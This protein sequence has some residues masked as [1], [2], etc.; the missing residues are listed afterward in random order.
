MERPH[1]LSYPNRF[2]ALS[3][4]PSD[5]SCLIIRLR[6]INL[7]RIRSKRNRAENTFLLQF[8]IF[9]LHSKQVSIFRHFSAGNWLKIWW[10]I[11]RYCKKRRIWSE[12]TNQLTSMFGIPSMI[13]ARSKSGRWLAYSCTSNVCAHT[14]I[15]RSISMNPRAYSV[16]RVMDGTVH[17]TPCTTIG[18]RSYQ[19]V[20]PAY[21]RTPTR[22]HMLL[23]SCLYVYAH[24][25]MYVLVHG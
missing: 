16:S 15:V 17:T 19:K 9:N 24:K 18:R 25:H 14:G 10:R 21:V 13:R 7:T 12:T 6:L 2:K 5:L 8:K 1:E 23:W 20:I 22:V 3:I 11:F 4:R